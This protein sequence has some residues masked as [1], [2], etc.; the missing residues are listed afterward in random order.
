[1]R[2]K[3]LS[4]KPSRRV[5]PPFQAV[6]SARFH[7]GW[8]GRATIVRAKAHL[9]GSSGAG[10][11]GS[12]PDQEPQHGEP[13][14]HLRRHTVRSRTPLP[15]QLDGRRVLRDPRPAPPHDRRLVVLAGAVRGAREP[16][17][18]D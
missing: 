8:K 2:R 4:K 14:D 17:P 6:V 18:R 10:Y 12:E 9:S 13:S 16:D 5:A 11:D 1:M 15:A 3:R 7:T